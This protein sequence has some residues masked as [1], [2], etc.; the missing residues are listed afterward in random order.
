MPEFEGASWAGGT[1]ALME[2]AYIRV[3]TTCQDVSKRIANQGLA[4]SH[5][6]EVEPVSRFKGRT[7]GGCPRRILQRQSFVSHLRLTEQQLRAL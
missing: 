6:S 7:W 3:H 5:T 4:K 2:R 1:S